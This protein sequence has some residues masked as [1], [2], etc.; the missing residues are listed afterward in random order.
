MANDPQLVNAIRPRL[1]SF[2]YFAPV[3]KG[4]VFRTWTNTF[5]LNGSGL[6]DLLERLAPLLDGRHTVAELVSGVPLVASQKI[7][8]LIQLLLEREVLTDEA[9]NDSQSLSPEVRNLYAASLAYLD[10]PPVSPTSAFVRFRASRVLMV[11][12]GL[13]A[14]ATARALFASGLRELS[15][16]VSDSSCGQIRTFEEEFAEHHSRDPQSVLTLLP[17]PTSC[18]AQGVESLA[19]FD[20]VLHVSTVAPVNSFQAL[21]SRCRS[22]GVRLLQATSLRGWG[23]VTP[24]LGTGSSC[25][26]E[27]VE[28]RLVAS[29]AVASTT[30]DLFLGNSAAFSAFRLLAGIVSPEEQQKLLTLHP[31]SYEMAR[32]VIIPHSCCSPTRAR[33]DEDVSGI[34]AL[35]TFASQVTPET[36]LEAT[37]AV[38]DPV[39]GLISLDHD[40]MDQVPLSTIRAVYRGPQTTDVA[41]LGYGPTP[42]EARYNAL[43]HVLEIVAHE[44][45]GA[46]LGCGVSIVT[47]RVRSLP[48]DHRVMASGHSFAEW[49]GRGLLECQRK[50]VSDGAGRVVSDSDLASHDVRRWLR[51]LRMRYRLRTQ[52]TIHALAPLDA[53]AA[54]VYVEGRAIACHAGRNDGEA[55]SAALY[56]AV[57]RIQA[58]GRPT[59]L[60]ILE[61]A[62]Q[63][64]GGDGGLGPLLTVEPPPTWDVWTSTALASL[65][66]ERLDVAARACPGYDVIRDAGLLIGAI[67]VLDSS[68]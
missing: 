57:A 46:E 50:R 64:D 4:V 63:S 8:A 62:A 52:V 60:L 54:T 25:C 40:N 1:R 61:R 65:V 3:S 67:A 9:K 26:W 49:V 24:V 14:R 43:R 29:A 7:C 19:E 34:D 10:T 15:V 6:Y 5:V 35:R 44:E 37:K 21:D 32:R 11:G 12:S 17:V 42:T 66:G 68:C 58:E 47:G 20:L 48:V 38:V 53:A 27:C 39:V 30:F 45:I 22:E 55:L 16:A 51:I 31:D 41:Y 36:F 56:S 23:I 59:G 2:V 33:A 13:I 28:R 18:G